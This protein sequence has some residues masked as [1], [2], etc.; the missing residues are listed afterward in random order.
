MSHDYPQF[1][2]PGDELRDEEYPDQGEPTSD[3]EDDSG[4]IC[5]HCGRCVFDDLDECPHCGTPLN[6]ARFGKNGPFW[7]IVVV[8]I[9]IAFV[10]TFVF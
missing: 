2:K 10:V 7:T 5:P 4:E 3:E 8:V 9:L 6:S 1:E